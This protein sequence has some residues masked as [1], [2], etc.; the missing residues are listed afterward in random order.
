VEET[1]FPKKSRSRWL[2]IVHETL[3]PV[4]SVILLLK[5]KNGR[6]QKKREGKAK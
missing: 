1:S 4:T 3:L 5:E 2:H 6:P